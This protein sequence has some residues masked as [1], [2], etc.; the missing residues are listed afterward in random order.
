MPVPSK[1]RSFAFATRWNR[2]M[3]FGLSDE[4]KS[5]RDQWNSRMRRGISLSPGKRLFGFIRPSIASSLHFS[6]R[7]LEKTK[8][9]AFAASAASIGLSESNPMKYR[10]MSETGS[11]WS[12]SE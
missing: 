10:S 9:L 3:T 5:V 8:D 12:G 2:L 1:E 6:L 4:P 7:G 11:Q